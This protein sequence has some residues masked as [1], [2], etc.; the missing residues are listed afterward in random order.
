MDAFSSA[1]KLEEHLVNLATQKRIPLGGSIELLPLCNMNCDMCY[2][3]LSKEEM[4]QKGKLRSVEEWINLAEEMKRSGVLFL[5]LTGGE[6]LLYPYFKELYL[7]LL[8]LGMILTIN[9][10]GTLI[11][12]E[13]AEFF[14]KHKPRRM[15]ITL[16]GKDAHTYKKLCHFE[17][18]FERTLHGIKLLK[19]QKVDVKLNGS[20]AKDNRNDAEVLLDI[21]D[22]LQVPMHIDTYMYP[23]EKEEGKEAEEEWRLSPKEAAKAKVQ[24]SQRQYGEQYRKYCIQMEQMGKMAEPEGLECAVKCRAGRSSFAINWQGSM[25]P[26]IMLQKISIN[27]FE[28]G[29]EKA[30]EETV[31]A[32]DEIKVS[33]RC[34]T[35]N[36]RKLC[37]SCAASAFLE[38]GK[39][40]GVPKYLCDYT[41]SIMKEIR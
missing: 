24:V 41:E 5:L 40:D 2:V 4:N 31:K 14:G 26:C 8:N 28:M 15:N 17:E 22:E 30:W 10:N 1:T 38:T 32:V 37:Q 21:A 36:L 9:T 6:P 33:K 39:Y 25:Q 34:G 23:V 16:Y 13:W 20:L 11:N 35:C 3:R 18:G 7:H 29:F 19:E 27:V 12:E